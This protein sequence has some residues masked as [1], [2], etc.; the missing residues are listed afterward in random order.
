MLNRKP[1]NHR[2]AYYM[3]FARLNASTPRDPNKFVEREIRWCKVCGA[4]TFAGGWMYPDRA[5]EKRR[6]KGRGR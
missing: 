5:I 1:C 6:A 4:I 2:N 3:G